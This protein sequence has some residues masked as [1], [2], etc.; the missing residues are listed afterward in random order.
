MGGMFA[1]AWTA[2]PE[3]ERTAMTDELRDAFKPFAVDNGYALPGLAICV[4]SS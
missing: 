3:E 4:L 1:R 2:A